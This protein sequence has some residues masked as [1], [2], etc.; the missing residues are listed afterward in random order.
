MDTDKIVE[1]LKKEAEKNQTFSLIFQALAKRERARHNL[2]I[3][4]LYQRMKKEG[5]KLNRTDYVD[6]ITIL[7]SY[8]VGELDY[9]KRGKVTGLKDIKISIPSL[10]R[11]ITK[12]APELVRI[13]KRRP[14]FETIPFKHPSVT[15]PSPQD[16]IDLEN[17]VGLDITLNNKRLYISIP[18]DFSS[19]DIANLVSKLQ[20]SPQ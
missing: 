17:R 13:Y 9:N 6:L 15:T 19:S 16:K 18:K 3:S 10:C 12:T 4:S 11:A 14:T 5:S 8:G 1:V 20:N 7:Y 2:T